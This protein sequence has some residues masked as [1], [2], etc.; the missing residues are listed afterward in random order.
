M[1][2]LVLYF[3]LGGSTAFLGV[4]PCVLSSTGLTVLSPP[5]DLDFKMLSAEA[6]NQFYAVAEY[7]ITNLLFVL[8][9][10]ILISR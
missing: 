5:A 7:T 6:G 10:L 4:S 9:L 2:F 1:I 8:I 3:H